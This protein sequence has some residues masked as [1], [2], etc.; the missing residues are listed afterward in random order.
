MPTLTNPTDI[1]R[2][3]LRLLATRRIPPTPE[4]YQRIYAELSGATATG[5]EALDHQL[6]NGVRLWRESSGNSALASLE[7]ALQDKDWPLVVKTLA[8][9]TQA[10]GARKDW[11]AALREIVK[12]FSASEAANRKTEGLDRLFAISGTD[13]QLPEKV[14]ALIRSWSTAR[15]VIPTVTEVH[16][17]ESGGEIEGATSQVRDLLAQTLDVGVAPRLERHPDLADEARLIAQHVRAALGASRW[18]RIAAQ[19]RQFWIKVELRSDADAEL[20][21]NLLKVLGLLVNNIGELIEED[22]WVSGQLE[23][24]RDLINQPLTVERIVQIERGFKDVVYKQSVLKHSLREAKSQLKGLLS[25]FVERLGEMT[26]STSDFNRKIEGYAE[27]LHKLDDI[28]GLRSLL[29][30]LMRDTR[31]MQTDMMRRQEEWVSAR[32]QAEAAERRVRQLEAELTQVSEQVREDQLTGALNRRGLEGAIEREI[33]RST[34]RNTPLCVAMLDLD[35]FKRL[36]DTY[37]H[38]AGDA[39]LVHLTKI[40]RRTVRPTDVLA[41][42]GGEEFVI[43]LGDANLDQA[44]TAMK[45]LQRELTKRFFLHNNERLLI[46]FSAGVALHQSG[47]AQ[48]SVISRADKAMYQAKIQG[49]NRVVAADTMTLAPAN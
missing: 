18:S 40:V 35:N 3:T 28:V 9:I 36:N 10:G 44:M 45:R 30:E 23:A 11:M 17:V 33:A 16:T 32:Q 26:T 20:L 42:Y 39:A 47:E 34:R 8:G 2:E 19:L 49:K 6:L 7:R 13:P 24:L 48:E 22:Q 14:V 1:A 27:R 25:T 4:N 38:Q 37:G 29:D 41:R 43:L 12:H 31:S 15:P 46:T 21:E 5:V